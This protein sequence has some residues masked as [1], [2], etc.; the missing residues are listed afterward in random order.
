MREDHDDLVHVDRADALDKLRGLAGKSVFVVGEETDLKGEAGKRLDAGKIRYDLIPADALHELAKVYT[1]G[2]AKY[3]D[4]NWLNGM[5][6][7]RCWGPL[8]RHAWKFW[9]GEEYDDEPGGT[10][11]HHMALV[12]WNAFALFVYATRRLGKDD[13]TVLIDAETFSRPIK[14]P[15]KAA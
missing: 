11:C 7:S 2:A 8:L 15:E 10:G 12:A 5:S 9:R 6:W 1:A 13:R 14:L 4:N 3:G